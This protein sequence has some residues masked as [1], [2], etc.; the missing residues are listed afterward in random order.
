MYRFAVAL[1]A[2]QVSSS[3]IAA[4]ACEWEGTVAGYVLCVQDLALDA[5]GL[6]ERLD[7]VCDPGYTAT[8]GGGCVDLTC[9]G[10]IGDVETDISSHEGAQAACE[11]RGARLCSL[12]E[13]ASTVD[14]GCGFDNAFVALQTVDGV[15][16]AYKRPRARSTLGACPGLGEYQGEFYPEAFDVIGSCGT[17]VL[18]TDAEN[19]V[20]GFLCCL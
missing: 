19:N 18:R 3:A 4:E 11:S 7:G 6:A 17:S 20:D 1:I 10:T 16:F 13:I 8:A 14:G 12:S 9:R 15:R 5:L 2:L